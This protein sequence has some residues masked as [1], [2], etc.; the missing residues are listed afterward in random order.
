[1]SIAND[2]HATVI[3]PASEVVRVTDSLA[4]WLERLFKVGGLT[5]V[6][7][8]VGLI[9]MIF[10][11][12]WTNDLSN[13]LFGIG[14]VI[15]FFCM[16]VFGFAQLYAPVQGR[17]L[18]RENK[19]LI[20]SVQTVAIRVTDTIGELQSLMFRHSKQVEVILATAVPLLKQTPLANMI[21]LSQ[22]ENLNALIIN[23]SQAGKKVVADVREALEKCDAT[24]LRV[25]ASQLEVLQERLRHALSQPN[26]GA[27]YSSVNDFATSLQSSALQYTDIVIS[28]NREVMQ[29]VNDID[30]VLSAL[31]R[32]PVIK[33]VVEQAGGKRA[34]KTIAALKHAST[35]AEITTAELQRAIS[36]RNLN[37]LKKSL[38]EMKALVDQFPRAACQETP[39]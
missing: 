28:A 25:Y 9:S 5:L 16:S 21:D 3:T 12:L 18:L 36:E 23:S 38:A 24:H 17:R 19:E 39:E 4:A 33:S 13:W 29:Y 14:A 31:A 7:V 8:F 37:A 10:A 34:A 32:V 1:M 11:Y 22:T 6:F 27:T 20:D 30:M 2:S 35:R 26:S 15:T